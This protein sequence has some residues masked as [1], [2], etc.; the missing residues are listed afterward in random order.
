[1]PVVSPPAPVPLPVV[2]LTALTSL[3][4]PAGPEM[5][6]ERLAVAEARRPFDLAEGPLLRTALVRLAP[7]RHHLLVTMHHIVSDGWS[8]GVFIGEVAELYRARL[9]G[10]A[11]EL[12]ALRL[13]Y[14]DFARL[15]E[16]RLGGG[17]LAAQLAHWR[18]RL[19]GLDPAGAVGWP[20]DRPRPVDPARR[21]AMAVAELPG[22]L[23]AGLARLARARGLSG[24]MV[25]LAIL[26]VLLRRSSG[27]DDLAVGTPIANRH[28]LES[29]G[30]I[31]LLVNTLVLRADLS[32]DPTVEDL[33]DRVRETALDAYAHQ[34]LP[35][36]RLVEELAPERRLGSNP[37]FEV[38]LVP[39]APDPRG[40]RAARAGGEGAAGRDGRGQARP[41]RSRRSSGTGAPG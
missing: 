34:D 17:L 16:R 28:R 35:F 14:G 5:E 11:P 26:L 41:G 31:G 21:G 13:Q 6:A 33:L 39:S 36:E 23:A 25:E 12:A 15:Q 2:D 38:M 19:A 20:H 4:G 30:L 22:D 8:M 1:M 40:A 9:E 7:G 24:F 27:R 29:E 37:L 10:R 18:E 32:G 3:A